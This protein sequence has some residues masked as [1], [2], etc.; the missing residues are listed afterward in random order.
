MRVC[1]D[2]LTVA[3]TP[4]APVG[5]LR[6]VQTGQGYRYTEER[7]FPSPTSHPSSPAVPSTGPQTQGCFVPAASGPP[8][9]L[10]SCAC[11]LS[12]VP[13]WVR[14]HL[15]LAHLALG[16]DLLVVAVRRVPGDL[17]G[18]QRD[19]HH[20]VRVADHQQ[21]EE[22]DQHGHADVVPARKWMGGVV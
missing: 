21:G 20:G 3:I 13:R 7:S 11:S 12:P 18:P 15:P 10:G 1:L 19:S 4:E 17:A 22:V 9:A 14:G 5:W 16:R 8:Q 2:G 6:P